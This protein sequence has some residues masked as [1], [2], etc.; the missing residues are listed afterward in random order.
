V[1]R[2]ICVVFSRIG[3][4]FVC[5]AASPTWSQPPVPTSA[6][7]VAE[8]ARRAY[9]LGRI[10]EAIDGFARAYQMSGEPGLLF[11]T[12]EAHR[13]LGRNADAVSLYRTYVQRAPGGPHRQA[14]EKAIEEIGRNNGGGDAK[15]AVPS[16][17]GA[18][19]GAKPPPAP[20]PPS[21]A[22]AALPPAPPPQPPAP[23]PA[24][25][26]APAT[27]TEAALATDLRG[28]AAPAPAERPRAVPRW[29][30]WISLA[31]T[32]ALGAGA[33]LSGLSASR[34]YD[35]LRTTCGRTAAGCTDQQI[36][37]VRSGARMA[38]VFWG[39][40]GVVAVGTGLA[41]YFSSRE[42]VVSAGATF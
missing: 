31:A 9:D 5:L 30:P 15:V 8:K 42:T 14:A 40:T 36:D 17:N 11:E 19:P 7:V 23:A 1:L 24:A 13:E 28:D 34:R 3:P 41:F 22:T 32:L 37:E 39:L 18:R 4:L 20:A 38:N 27:V 29:L 35:E 6:R 2:F 12:A 21:A 25:T 26:P 33:V 16:E 10:E